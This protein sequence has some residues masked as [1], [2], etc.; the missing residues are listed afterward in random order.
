[1]FMPLRMGS[2]VPSVALGIKDKANFLFTPLFP[3]IKC[4]EPFVELQTLFVPFTWNLSN[5]VM[6]FDERG[7]L[8]PFRCRPFQFENP[9]VDWIKMKYL[10]REPAISKM[11]A[12]LRPLLEPE[13]IHIED[14]GPRT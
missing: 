2:L 10:T 8:D 6:A 4:E 9:L 1:M 12:F 13:R 11:E 3:N 14:R 7:T 5:G